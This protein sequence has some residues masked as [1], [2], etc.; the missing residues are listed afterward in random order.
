MSDENIVTGT[1][2]G[3]TIPDA[4]KPEI[5]ASAEPEMVRKE[6]FQEVSNDMHKYKSGMKNEKARANEAEAKLKAYEDDQL[7]AKE[8]YQ[9]LYENEKAA[10]IKSEEAG[11]LKDKKMSDARKKAALK[12][13]LGNVKDAYLV[14]ANLDSIEIGDDDSL[15]SESVLEVANK[16]RSDYPELIPSS[17]SGNITNQAA[18]TG[19]VTSNSPKSLVEMTMEEKIEELARRKGLL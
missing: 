1:M 8:E 4:V 12:T 18:R 2:T 6:A 5:Q 10:R 13:E 17:G 9:T 15:N 11:L 7:K 19:D 14:H 3:D 16:F